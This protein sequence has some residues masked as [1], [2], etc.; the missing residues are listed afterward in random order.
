MLSP[1]IRG[2]SVELQFTNTP[3]EMFHLGMHTRWPAWRRSRLFFPT[4]PLSTSPASTS[5]A[6]PVAYI[7]CS[8]P[9]WWQSTKAPSSS[10]M[11]STKLLSSISTLWSADFFFC[12]PKY[13][14]LHLSLLHF[15]ILISNLFHSLSRLF[16]VLML[17]SIM[18]TLLSI[19]LSTAL[20]SIPYMIFFLFYVSFSLKTSNFSNVSVK[21]L[22]T[23]SQLLHVIHC[24]TRSSNLPSLGLLVLS[25]GT[26]VLKHWWTSSLSATFIKMHISRFKLSQFWFSRLEKKLQKK[27]P[28]KKAP[29]MTND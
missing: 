20:I 4:Q 5:P 21:D 15:N 9:S 8:L 11:N 13:R 25:P 3:L 27:V 28:L 10:F 23:A 16:W 19:E 14:I 26:V 17:S 24:V 6:F 18:L 29:Q 22:F 1:R 12:Q 2:S 7:L